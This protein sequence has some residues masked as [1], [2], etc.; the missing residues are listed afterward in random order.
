MSNPEA[1]PVSSR[2]AVFAALRA[3]LRALRR[4][5]RALIMLLAAQVVVTLCLI[6]NRWLQL[7]VKA[8]PGA[9]SPLLPI[10]F[11]AAAE[12]VTVSALCF[13]RETLVL[14]KPAR[15][16]AFILPCTRGAWRGVSRTLLLLACVILLK[17]GLVCL[18][19]ASFL[20]GALF[21]ASFRLLGFTL[22]LGATGLLMLVLTLHARAG[23]A[24]SP[25]T[26]SFFAML[27]GIK[28]WLR[29]LLRFSLLCLFVTILLPRPAQ[30]QA[31]DPHLFFSYFIYFLPNDL[32]Q[33]LSYATLPFLYGG[34][35]AK[36]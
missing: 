27:R 4:S 13:A 17:N 6:L 10:L 32:I 33:L 30:P 2:P 5:P 31:D 3:G 18:C 9:F 1:E 24:F 19:S 35:G 11:D 26:G 12:L 20:V 15:F 7:N 22:C 23:F 28:R 29:A 14:E 36:D 25:D 8:V 16:S 21:P 34:Q